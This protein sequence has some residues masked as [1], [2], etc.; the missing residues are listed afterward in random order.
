MKIQ[1]NYLSYLCT[2]LKCLLEKERIYK[3]LLC[4]IVLLEW[5]LSIKF[6]NLIQLWNRHEAKDQIKSKIIRKIAKN[7]V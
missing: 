1:T 7:L 2:E 3:S 6:N 4:H 5:Y